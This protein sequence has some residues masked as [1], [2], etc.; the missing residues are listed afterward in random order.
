VRQFKRASGHIVAVPDGVDPPKGAI[1][2][3]KGIKMNA[4]DLMKATKEVSNHPC[5]DESL[6]I[7]W[8]LLF[9]PLLIHKRA[10]FC[11]QDARASQSL[12]Q[13]TRQNR[14]R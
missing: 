11:R 2:I 12:Y 4:S 13:S 14:R 7:W 10:V 8:S 9:L 6:L 5:D 3:P 1:S